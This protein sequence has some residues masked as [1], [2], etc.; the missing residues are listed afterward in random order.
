MAI[1]G[2]VNGA[3]GVA[4]SII[5]IAYTVKFGRSGAVSYE[6]AGSWVGNIAV[7]ILCLTQTF[8]TSNLLRFRDMANVPVV[9]LCIARV[10]VTLMIAGWVA[11]VVGL[12]IKEYQAFGSI[13]VAY[14]ISFRSIQLLAGLTYPIIAWVIFSRPEV[15]EL[16]QNSE[17]GDGVD[18]NSA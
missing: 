14:V 13:Y 8:V 5:A 4:M 16:Y 7:M 6:V 12:R 1:I 11:V 15:V 2:I 9:R 3:A 18:S 17:S 10:V